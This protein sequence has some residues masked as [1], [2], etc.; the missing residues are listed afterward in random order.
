MQQAGYIA[1]LILPAPAFNGE[2]ESRDEAIS[3]HVV[4]AI[5]YSI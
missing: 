3:L 5:L 4:K 1:L 2:F